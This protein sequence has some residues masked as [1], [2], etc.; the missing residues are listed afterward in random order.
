MSELRRR[1]LGGLGLD[2]SQDSSPAT[3]REAS[4]APGQR[5]GAEY[6]V[7]PKKTLQK[8]KEVKAK[9]TKRRNA[10]IFAFGSIFGIFIAG[11]FAS[12]NGSLDSVLDMAGVKEMRLDT[13]LDVLPAGLIKDVQ[14]IQVCWT[15]R[16]SMLP[17]A[18]VDG[19]PLMAGRGETS[20]RLRF[21]QNW[22]CSQI[23]RH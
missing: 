10:W 4:P 8:L 9:G 2:S 6:K 13:L 23:A 21:F 20:R 3:S 18:D 16:A 7:V 12:S 1:V 14:N 5:D 19:G 15:P 22:S 17:Q 11:Y